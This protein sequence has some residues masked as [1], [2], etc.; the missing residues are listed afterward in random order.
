VFAVESSALALLFSLLAGAATTIGALIALA[1]KRTSYRAL[2]FGTGFSAGVMMYISFAELLS[3]ATSSVGFAAANLFFFAGFLAMAILDFTIPHIYEEEKTAGVRAKASKLDKAGTLVFL[4]VFLHNFPEGL[5]AF[6]G[7]L[8]DAHL[9]FLLLLAVAIHNIPE[10]VAV[11]M[12]TYYA[13]GDKKRAFLLS[14]LSGL[15][16]PLGAL[17]SFVLLYQFITPALI[18]AML[19]CVAGLMVFISFDELLPMSFEHGEEH[20]AIVGISLGMLLMAISL[21]VLK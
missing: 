8:K 11:Y 14:V 3:S 13:T 7:T 4:G 19:A 18:G 12:P 17:L 16:E 9:G 1:A 6:F 2:S 15:A 21:V 20:T 10:G 5:V